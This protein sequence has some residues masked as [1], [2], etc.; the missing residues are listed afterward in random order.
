MIQPD[1]AWLMSGGP[2]E[3]QQAVEVMRRLLVSESQRA[4]FAEKLGWKGNGK[5]I[6]IFVPPDSGGLLPKGSR[7]PQTNLDQALND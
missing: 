1:W 7:L 4:S 5:A 2:L 6:L 3:K